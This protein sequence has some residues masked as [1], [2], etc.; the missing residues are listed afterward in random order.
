MERIAIL[1]VAHLHVDAY[2]A[3]LRASSAEVIGVYDWDAERG[4]AW[5]AAHAVPYYADPQVLL[6]EGID[7][8][9]IC[10]ETAHHRELVE[11]AASAGA[12]VL[13]E[14]PLGVGFEDSRAIVQA[15]SEAG[16]RLMTA[17][18]IRFD[19]SVTRIRDMIRRGDMGAVHAF[20]GTNQSVMP[21]RERSWFADQ[22]LAGGGA[23]MDHIVHL[24]DVYSWILGAPPHEVYAVNNRIVH[25]HAVTVETSG[26]AVLSYP[27]GVFATIDCSWNRPL[28]YPSWGG[29]AFSVVADAGTL[30]TDVFRQQL[31][32][33]GGTRD[34]SWVPFGLDTNQLMIDEFLASIREDREP[35]VTGLDGLAATGVALAALE[36][37]ATGRP[38]ALTADRIL[39]PARPGQ[40]A[41]P[42]SSELLDI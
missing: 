5:A 15:C 33:F 13:C 26:L 6:A 29:M 20:T 17:F 22:R 8:V 19:R 14:K 12:A 37:A 34:L 40:T 32:Q 38:V 11:L 21:M 10:S 25:N 42:L 31:T 27:N 39:A 2:I 18:P 3:N 4:S 36:S 24:A 35:L 7:G 9:I 41:A 1:G 16:V 28:S 23:M 30:E